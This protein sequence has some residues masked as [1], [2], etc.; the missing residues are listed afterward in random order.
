MESSHNLSVNDYVIRR[1]SADIRGV[2]VGVHGDTVQV[3]W[4][5][6]TCTWSSIA[7]LVRCRRRDAID[8]DRPRRARTRLHA[9]A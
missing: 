6:Y 7:G 1:G 5:R 2:V 8:G 3:R 9:R 4:S